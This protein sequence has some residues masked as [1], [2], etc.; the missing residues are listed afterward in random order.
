[1]AKAALMQEHARKV[2]THQEKL[3]EGIPDAETEI[4][5]PDPHFL[6][7]EGGYTIRKRVTV[8]VLPFPVGATYVFRIIEAIRTSEVDDGKFGAARVCQIESPGGE[9][10]VLI[11]GEVL[12]T[13]LARA[14]PDDAYVGGWFQVTKLPPREGKRYADYAI[15]EVEPPTAA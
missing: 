1:M 8:P 12:A 7:P 9:V 3:S 13:S 6:V 5:P 11:A 15:V 10:R 4:V 14:Y 2:L